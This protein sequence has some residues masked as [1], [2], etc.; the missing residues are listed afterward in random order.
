M[1]GIGRRALLTGLMGGL[2]SLFV[3]RWAM[4]LGP[5]SRLRLARVAA[6]GQPPGRPGAERRLVWELLKRTSVSAELESVQLQLDDP[7][8]FEHPLAIWASERGHP[9]LSEAALGALARYLRFGGTLVAESCGGE[10]GAAFDAALRRSLQR[11]L[12][13]HP[14]RPLG[15][16]HTIY[17]SFYLLDRPYGRVLQRSYLEGVTIGG[18]TALVYSQNDLLGAW[19]RD[20][21]GSWQFPVIPGG[22]W[23]R[24]RAIRLGV[25]VLMYA[26][27]LDYKKDQVHVETL[28]RRRRWRSGETP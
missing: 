25:N 10:S 19:A 1:A 16:D 11:A 20:S 2:G 28:M 22:Q 9:P 12:P 15:N 17:R 18:R 4:A 5:T 27:C 6:A 26:L 3:G 8:L 21:L 24:E 23:Q 7:S 13:E 14:L